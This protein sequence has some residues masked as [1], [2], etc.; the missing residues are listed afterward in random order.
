VWTESGKVATWV[1][2]TLN[3]VAAKLEQPAVAFPEFQEDKITS[4]CVSSLY[5]CAKLESGA[6]YWWYALEWPSIVHRL[7]TYFSRGIMPFGQRKKIV[8]K[9]RS[10]G[11]KTKSSSSSSKT[12]PS[13]FPS[14]GS[15]GGIV[16]GM[17]VCLRAAPIYHVGAIGFTCADGVPRVGQLMEAA[18]SLNDTCRFK[19]KKRL[20]L[21]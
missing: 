11:K 21:M 4:V 15:A 18:W 10:R 9:A 5:T 1:D 17:Q 13:S 2:E 19:I 7:S 12:P 3:I 16:V 20:T 14:E 6:L 8:E